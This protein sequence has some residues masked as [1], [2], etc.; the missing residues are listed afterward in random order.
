[1]KPLIINTSS[2]GMFRNGIEMDTDSLSNA[3]GK[4]ISFP[5]DQEADC[6]KHPSEFNREKTN[7]ER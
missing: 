5:H 3:H 7:K 6:V 1:M 2:N 4:L